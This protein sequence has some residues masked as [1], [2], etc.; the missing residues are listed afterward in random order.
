MLSF[1]L[2]LGRQTGLLPSDFP[3]KTLYAFGIYPTR[4]TCSTHLLH[5]NVLIVIISGEEHKLLRSSL[6]IYS[7]PRY[8]LSTRQ[9][10]LLVLK[11]PPLG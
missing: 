2:C 11:Y 7:I 8:F 9:H 6:R 3:T 5:P 10:S 4:A 1:R